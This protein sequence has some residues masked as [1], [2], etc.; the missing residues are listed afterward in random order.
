[1]ITVYGLHDGD[2][3]IRY[4]GRTRVTLTERLRSHRSHARAGVGTPVYC[5]M[6]EVDCAVQVIPL[7]T[8]EDDNVADHVEQEFIRAGHAVSPDL[9]NRASGGTVGF[10]QAET[11]RKATGSKLKGRVFSPE[12]RAKMSEAAYRRGKARGGLNGH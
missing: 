1:M 11:S 3:R 6:R 12:T 5:W 10:R 7:A 9:L 8:F 2:F 4:I